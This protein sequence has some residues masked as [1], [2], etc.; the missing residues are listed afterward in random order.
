M[1]NFEFFKL[2]YYLSFTITNTPNSYPQSVRG[3]QIWLGGFWT[4][5]DVDRGW[6]LIVYRSWA[7][8]S[9]IKPYFES[10]F[11]IFCQGCKGCGTTLTWWTMIFMIKKTFLVLL[12]CGVTF[13]SNVFFYH[14]YVI[15]WKQ[16]IFNY[17]LKRVNETGCWRGF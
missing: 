17:Q 2:F 7:G 6:I 9:S 8:T 3:S 5:M 15:F 14:T 4:R 10:F 1:Y 13:D 11:Y 12:Q 16:W